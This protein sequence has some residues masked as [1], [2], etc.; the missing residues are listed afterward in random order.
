MAR[1]SEDYG[2]VTGRISKQHEQE[3][4]ALARRAG[5]RESFFYGMAVMIGARVLARNL[6]LPE[7]TYEDTTEPVR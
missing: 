7:P 4:R 1:I 3:L 5:I 6:G 2:S